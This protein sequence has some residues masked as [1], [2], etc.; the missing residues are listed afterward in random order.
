MI[1]SVIVVAKIYISMYKIKECF[2]NT[3]GC[4]YSFNSCSGNW[5]IK[6]KLKCI[7]TL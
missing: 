6:Y 1:N 3:H 2:D 7:T 4:K 5:K